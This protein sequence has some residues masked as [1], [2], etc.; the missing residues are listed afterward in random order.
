M[1]VAM[2]ISLS[3]S[4]P[5]PHGSSNPYEIS[6]STFTPVT[7]I[8]P[9]SCTPPPTHRLKNT[10]PCT[11]TTLI[12]DVVDG[13]TDGEIHSKLYRERGLLL[14]SG[15]RGWQNFWGRTVGCTGGT[16]GFG[17]SPRSFCGLRVGGGKPR[18]PLLPLDFFLSPKSFCGLR[19]GG[20]QC[21]TTLPPPSRC[22]PP[23][24]LKLSG[25]R[26]EAHFICLPPPCG[27]VPIHVCSAMWGPQTIPTMA[28][29]GEHK[30]PYIPQKGW[31]TFHMYAASL[32]RV[33]A[34]I[35]WQTYAT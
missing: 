14:L 29:C 34:R 5:A 2:A 33:S 7:S 12:V 22:L 30:T 9:A 28:C 32:L 26:N 11:A 24:W 21:Q 23:S 4:T 13:G 16:A 20:G 18:Q 27:D 19:A 31:Q 15:G 1:V 3:T 8:P 6:L 17:L 35:W 25:R 10:P